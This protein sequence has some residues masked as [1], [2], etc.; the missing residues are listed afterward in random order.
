MSKRIEAVLKGKFEEVK[1]QNR[2]SRMEAAINIAK[3]NAETDLIAVEDEKT[4]TVELL[5]NAEQDV[6]EVVN[7]LVNLFR[8]EDAIK[9]TK[10]Y[11][12]R[13]SK[14]LNEEIKDKS[15]K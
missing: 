15:A 8:K 12:D 11:L 4:Q 3:L 9:E 1:I 7:N 6:N 5:T 13:V 10:A 2:I 14:Y